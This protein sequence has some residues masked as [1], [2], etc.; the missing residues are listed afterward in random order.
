MVNYNGIGSV[1][2]T[3]D[4][5]LYILEKLLDKDNQEIIL[6]SQDSR[7]ISSRLPIEIP[8]FTK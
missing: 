8:L 6:K 7:S 1:P 3:Q 4:E 2:I 5:A